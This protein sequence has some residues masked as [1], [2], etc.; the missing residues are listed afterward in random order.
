MDQAI[1]KIMDGRSDA[2]DLC[3]H[4]KGADQFEKNVTL[5]EAKILMGNNGA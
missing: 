1:W 2:K 4:F 5:A 3:D